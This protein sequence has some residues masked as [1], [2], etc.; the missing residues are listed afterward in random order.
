MLTLPS[1]ISGGLCKM[2]A[3]ARM[4]TLSLCQELE[5]SQLLGPCLDIVNPPL[6]EV[7]HLGWFQEFW[8]IRYSE[9]GGLKPSI[10]ENADR[11]YDSARVEH[12]SRW[13]L[14]LPKMQDTLAYLQS[15]QDIVFERAL[16]QEEESNLDYF[17]QLAAF[18]EQMHCEAFL[19]TRQTLGYTP[20]ATAEKSGRHHHTVECPGDVHIAGGCF[21]LG[22]SPDEKFVFDNEKWAH[23]V[24][25]APFSM[26]RTPVTNEQFLAF[27]QDDG[28][29]R[30]ELWSMSG[31]EWR[32]RSAAQAPVYW[33]YFGDVWMQRRYAEFVEL[34]PHEPVIHVNWYEAQA[35]CSWA[36]R[37]LPTEVEW[38]Y[39]ASTAGL[40][41]FKRRYPWGD[42]IPE[43][44]HSN[45]WTEAGEGHCVDVAEFVDGDSNWGCRQMLGNVWEWTADAFQ[46]YP[47]FECDPYKEYSVPWFGTHK[48][49]RGGSFATSAVLMRNTFR[50]FYTPDR[51]DIFAG[52][53]TCAL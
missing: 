24:E 36:G 22:A 13:H 18:H 37:R 15:V 7:G 48:V 42:E 29:R 38:E 49:L 14:P 39:A 16:K 31:W 4:R 6:W 30:R 10:M 21:K 28:Y 20:P 25:L 3:D 11:L 8:C 40:S 32:M 53:R 46:P 5:E 47:G 43:A 51:R 1:L 35:Y 26:A 41:G 19:Y 34:R 45:L 52:F 12:A 50:N 27:V 44:K 2:L 9:K 23:E 17:L 33:Q